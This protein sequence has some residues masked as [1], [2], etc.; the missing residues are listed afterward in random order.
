[1]RQIVS[2]DTGEIIEYE[3]DEYLEKKNN[4]LRTWQVASEEIKR[5]SVIKKAA[6]Q[7]YIELAGNPHTMKGT[8]WDILGDGW[9]CKISK[10]AN[11]GFKKGSDGK[12]DVKLLNLA[13]G[14][15][16]D[17]CDN[18]TSIAGELVSWMPR[19]SLSKYYALSPEATAIIDRVAVQGKSSVKI[20][21]VAP[22][23]K[24]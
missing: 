17:K 7:E 3:D 12:V 23:D 20:E 22:K 6:E 15:I 13:L 18:G 11:Y 21:I 1:M 9:R 14:E 16:A 4:A 8:Q 19:L 24:K 5:L 2:L 10:T